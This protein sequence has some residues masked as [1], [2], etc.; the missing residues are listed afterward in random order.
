MSTSN[1]FRGKKVN[2]KGKQLS[3]DE[4]NFLGNLV[5]R[6]NRTI[7]QVAEFYN[8]NISTVGN[9]SKNIRASVGTSSRN[10][11][12]SQLDSISDGILRQFSNG[13]RSST[14][15]QDLKVKIKEEYINTQR[16]RFKHPVD[17]FAAKDVPIRTFFR[18]VRKYKTSTS[19]TTSG[20]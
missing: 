9:Y 7:V 6:G 2:L 4:K 10:G 16:R 20:N 5:A 18:H 8:L 12:P 13:P 3:V 11:R 17:T 15:L 1:I 19:S 14:F